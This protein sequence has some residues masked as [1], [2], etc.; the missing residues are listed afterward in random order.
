MLEF[1]AGRTKAFWFYPV[2]FGY[3]LLFSGVVKI[4]IIVLLYLILQA[5]LL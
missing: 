3:N 2:S 5:S 1:R 4:E